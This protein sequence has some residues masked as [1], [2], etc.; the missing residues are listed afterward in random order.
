MKFYA[1]NDVLLENQQELRITLREL[2]PQ[3]LKEDLSELRDVIN[4]LKEEIKAAREAIW[5]QKLVME[6]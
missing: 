2:F 1:Y 5:L 3:E 4:M 6:K